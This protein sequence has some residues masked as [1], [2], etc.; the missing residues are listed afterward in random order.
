[1]EGLA[2]VTRKG[3]ITIPKAFREYL[4]VNS[5]DKLKIKVKN[6]DVVLEST[7]NLKNAKGILNQYT[8]NSPIKDVLKAREFMGNNYE[9]I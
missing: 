2:T 6:G 4:N 7:K 5:F 8:K 9:R 1:M 3:Q